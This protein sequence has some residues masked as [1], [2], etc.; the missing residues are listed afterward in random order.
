MKQSANP[1]KIQVGTDVLVLH[2][3]VIIF[4]CSEAKLRLKRVKHGCQELR[5]TTESTT[6]PYNTGFSAENCTKATKYLS[7]I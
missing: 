3:T 7:T 2:G 1:R 5:F 4:L 6:I